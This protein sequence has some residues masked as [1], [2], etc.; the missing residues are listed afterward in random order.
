M[1]ICNRRNFLTSLSMAGFVV[2]S[3]SHFCQ[4]SAKIRLSVFTDEISDDF[5]KAVEIAA[6]EFGLHWVEVRNLWGKHLLDLTSTEMAEARRLLDRYQL[7]VCSIA[8]PLFK[9]DWPDSPRSRHSPGKGPIPADTLLIQDTVL[10]K[11]I[12][13]ALQ[14]GKPPLRC[15]DFWR[16]DDAA[17]HRRSIN[18]VLIQAAQKAKR[19][20]ITLMLENEPSCN[21]GTAR[22]AAEVLRAIPNPNFKLLWDPANSWF[23]GADPFPEGYRLLPPHRIAHVH[24]KDGLRNE[25]GGLEWAPI[26]KGKIDFGGL[27]AAMSRDGFSGAFSLE[28]HWHGAGS[29]EESTR[30]SM[31][32]LKE[33][34]EKAHVQWI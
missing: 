20:D 10:E 9:A 19:R 30:Q 33:A 17:P 5:G 28:T 14:L 32:G 1:T 21:T 29:A 2:R 7:R 6:R 16:L 23:A 4:S 18:Q 31:K 8:S 12:E 3:S 27:F 15:F 24:C 26:G 22:E 25:K 11:G 34:L 13:A